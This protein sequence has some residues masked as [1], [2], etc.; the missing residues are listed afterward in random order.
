MVSYNNLTD[1]E[2]R[3]IIQTQYTENKKSFG[4]I[5][6]ECNTYSNRLLRDAK[7]F[8]IPIRT[9]SEAQKN[10]LSTG[11]HKHP[12]KGRQRSESEKMNIGS[13]VMKNWSKADAKR[14]AQKKESAKI[15]WEKKTKEEKQ[16][17]LSKA[18]VAVRKSSKIGSK[19]EHYILDF[20]VANNYKVDFHKEDILVNTRLQIDLFL[21]TM[22]I[23]IEVDG[24]SHF[25]P[26]W[27]EEVL[28]RNIAY[29]QKKSGLIVGKGYRLI[30]IKQKRDFSKSRAAMVCDKLKKT[31]DSIQAT[32][33][34]IIEIEDNNG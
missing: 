19:M 22:N 12:T 20:L 27:G 13:G 11:A 5:A 34:K 18:N 25:S 15:L 6:K 31:L 14:L 26:V 33:S 21:P 8:N 4:T 28:S 23:A 24:P 17:M 29:D 30:R 1:S 10:A 2:K 9:K 32:S 7:K 3:R 16:L